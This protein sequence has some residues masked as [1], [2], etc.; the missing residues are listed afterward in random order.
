MEVPTLR[1]KVPQIQ[2]G[3]GLTPTDSRLGRKCYTLAVECLPGLP[4][5]GRDARNC[6][7]GETPEGVG[8]PQYHKW[9]NQ[10]YEAVASECCYSAIWSLKS[11]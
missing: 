2:I 1:W 10:V 9:R 4:V 7:A 6:V 8:F 11:Y 5:V 3:V